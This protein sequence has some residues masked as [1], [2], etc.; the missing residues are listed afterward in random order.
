MGKE[1]VDEELDIT[2][3]DLDG[4]SIDRR[5]TMKLLS[6]V[7][8]AGLAGCAGGGGGDGDGDGDEDGA[9]GDG[10]GTDGGGGSNSGQDRSGKRYGGRLKAGWNVAQM[11]QLDPHYS[12]LTQATFAIGN[13]FSGLTKIKKDLTVQGDLAKDWTVENGGERITFDLVENAK[14]HNGEDFTSEDVKYSINRVL[15]KDT[16]HKAK[17]SSLKPVDDGG[18]NLPDEYTVELNFQKAFAP[19][20]L[21]L[22]PDVGNAGAIVNQTAIE[23][24]GEDQYKITP[25]GTGP[26]K[27][28]EHQLGSTMKTDAFEDYF[29]TDENGNPLPYLDGV[30]YRPIQE[31][32]TRVSAMRT[33]DIDFMSLVPAEQVKTLES[34]NNVVIEK[35]LG[36][37]F[38]GLAFNCD[39]EPFTDKRV[40]L[41]V[42]KAFDRERYVDETFFGLGVGDTGIITPASAWAYRD[43]S[44]SAPDQKPTDQNHDPEGARKLAEEAG[45]IGEKVE[46]TVAQPEMRGAKIM[47]NML[48]EVLDW[49]VELNQKDFPTIFEQV[50]KGN[51]T[52]MPWG[53]SSA[54]DPDMAIYP[55][56]GPPEEVSNWWNYTD[57]VE[58]AEEQRTMLDREERKQVLWEIEDQLIK[59][60]P[61]AFLEHTEAISA[62]SKKLKNYSHFGVIMRFE[63]VWLDE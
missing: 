13:I 51:F 61:W 36:P 50:P 38:G 25:V 12:E 45:V 1:Y 52:F 34:S 6:A 3:E 10:G 31:A 29:N 41:A 57:A 42:A 14:F 35:A 11:E 30:D 16:A 63:N 18:V 47:R 2:Q 54:P 32:T 40:R 9:G 8:M 26:F 22:T 43:E 39:A 5:T 20:M 58:K 49:E 56:F 37:N 59:D 15:T 21:F 17:F 28:V 44:G 62:R 53:T 4:P 33:G 55:Q 7:G 46:M 48:R 60:A 19:I 27:I 24:M 23:E